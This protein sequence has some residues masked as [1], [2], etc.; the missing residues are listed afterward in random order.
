MDEAWRMFE[1]TGKVTDYLNYCRQ[2]KGENLSEKRNTDC[3]S[4]T[5]KESKEREAGW[6]R[7]SF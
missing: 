2:E 1:T 5:V 3:V 4:G 7:Q 6:D